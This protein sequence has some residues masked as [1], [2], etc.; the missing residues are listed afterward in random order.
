MS[1]Y[2]L[3]LGF[4]L[5]ALAG[6]IALIA[7]LAVTYYFVGLLGA[8]VFKRIRRIYHLTVIGYWLDRL[9]KGGMRVFQKSEE[10]DANLKAKGV[11]PAKDQ[12]AA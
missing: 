5:M 8:E 11:V 1:T 3:I 10:Y 4:G 12:E 9:E 2:A 7:V 6:G